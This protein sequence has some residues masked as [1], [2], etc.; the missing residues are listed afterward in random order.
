MGEMTPGT[1]TQA[2]ARHYKT[3]GCENEEPTYRYSL[4]D[5][6]K[7]DFLVNPVVVDARRR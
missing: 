7:D 6:V 2:A 1:R 4:L 3:F 5:G